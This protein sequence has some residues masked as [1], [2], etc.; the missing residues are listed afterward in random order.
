VGADVAHSRNYSMAL[1]ASYAPRLLLRQILH[2]NYSPMDSIVHR[3]R[4]DGA[5]KCKGSHASLRGV[6]A[7][8]QLSQT[9]SHLRVKRHASRSHH[10][11]TM[12]QAL[13][14][15]LHSSLRHRNVRERENL[16]IG[17]VVMDLE[18]L[19]QDY[20]GSLRVA[21][22]FL[23]TPRDI[24]SQRRLQCIVSRIYHLCCR[25]LRRS[26]KAYHHRLPSSMTSLWACKVVASSIVHRWRDQ[27][28][29]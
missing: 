19:R 2:S 13:P 22:A 7:D 16:P 1:A 21:Y 18:V 6:Q 15:R 17:C 28:Q 3:R 23:R 12:I 29:A 27:I 24:A 25:N 20:R 8:A 11:H 10:R 26:T 9:E 5:S 14:S 4:V